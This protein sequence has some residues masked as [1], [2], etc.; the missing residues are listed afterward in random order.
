MNRP[1]HQ[2]VAAAVLRRIF[3]PGAK[4]IWSFTDFADLD[5]MAVAAALS[6]LSRAGRLRRVRRGIYHR[7]RATAFGETRPDPARVADAI[8]SER[9][10]IPMR[11]Y[12]QLGLTSQVANEMRRAV[13][14]PTRI[15]PIRGIEMRTVTRP[16]LRQEGITETE[17]LIL[18]AL[19]NI[20]RIPDTSVSNTVKRIKTLIQKRHLRPARLVRFALAEPPR[21]R[22]LVGAM[23]DDLDYRGA[24][25]KKLRQKLNPLTTYDV[26]G[27]KASLK[28]AAAWRIR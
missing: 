9:T 17:R 12:N 25:L 1:K 13:E 5:P 3:R 28:T 15:K 19:R 22:A 7:P 2:S 20:S 24:G 11:G 16:L 23:V 18:D 4:D 27:V 21:V 10:S 26:P 8:F 14:S 6:R